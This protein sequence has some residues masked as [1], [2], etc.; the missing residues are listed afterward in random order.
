MK[1]RASKFPFQSFANI[2][3]QKHSSEQTQQNDRTIFLAEDWK[4]LGSHTRPEILRFRSE[5]NLWQHFMESPKTH[6]QRLPSSDKQVS[7]FLFF[8]FGPNL[9]PAEA[10]FTVFEAYD[11]DVKTV[12]K[13]N[14]CRSW[15]WKEN[16]ENSNSASLMKFVSEF[17]TILV[18]KK[19]SE[20]FFQQSKWNP[21]RIHCIMWLSPWWT[22]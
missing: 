4:E 15:E 10:L 5:G 6:I 17:S 8:L 12:G 22:D 13:S 18:L 14:I 1:R 9:F 21:K 11:D 7:F 16:S 20:K 19:R 3:K 2:F